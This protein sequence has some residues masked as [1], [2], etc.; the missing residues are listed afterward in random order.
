MVWSQ[1]A[2][3]ILSSIA[4]EIVKDQR[5]EKQKR[6]ISTQFFPFQSFQ[7]FENLE[8]DFG[9]NLKKCFG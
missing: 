9:I 2:L 6:I 3:Q 8:I 5:E 7:D 1:G 4:F